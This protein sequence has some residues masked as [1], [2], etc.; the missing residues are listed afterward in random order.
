MTKKMNVQLFTYTIDQKILF[1]YT[2]FNSIWGIKIWIYE[3]LI[4]NNNYR[5]IWHWQFKNL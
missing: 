4:D 5:N 3:F 1:T 2:N